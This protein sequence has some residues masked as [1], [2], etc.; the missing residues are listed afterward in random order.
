MRLPSLRSLLIVGAVSLAMPLVALAAGDV[1]VSLSAHRILKT[2]AGQEK[3]APADHAKP[4]EVIEYQAL[5]TNSGRSGV[6]QMVATLPIPAGTQYLP[7]TAAPQ[8]ALASVD[9]QH[10]EPIPLKRRV[11]LADG[12]EVTRDVPFAEYRYLRWTLGDMPAGYSRTVR[13]RV[14]VENGPLASVTTTAQGD[15]TR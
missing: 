4:G 2:S 7:T 1:Q 3:L 10:F 6:H 5:Y 15:K 14:R 12:S 8:T 13:A 11:R 9:G